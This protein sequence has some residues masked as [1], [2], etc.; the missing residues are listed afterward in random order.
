MRSYRYYPAEPIH[1]AGV[2]RA[3]L[4][5]FAAPR[6]PQGLS[7]KKISLDHLGLTDVTGDTILIKTAGPSSQFKACG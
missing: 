7:S 5:L 1:P 4:S 3:C 2:H 6:P